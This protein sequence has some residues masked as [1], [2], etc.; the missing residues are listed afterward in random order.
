M[1]VMINKFKF[2]WN[3]IVNLPGIITMMMMKVSNDENKFLVHMNSNGDLIFFFRQTIN[4]FVVFLNSFFS[5]LCLIPV[6]LI[7]LNFLSINL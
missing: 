3:K 7:V 1:I 6:K 5:L 4:V 2:H